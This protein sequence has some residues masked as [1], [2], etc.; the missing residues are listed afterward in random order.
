MID[1]SERINTTSTQ[2]SW[3]STSVFKYCDTAWTVCYGLFI[4]D[5]TIDGSSLSL[6]L[7][8]YSNYIKFIEEVKGELC[9][10]IKE[11]LYNCYDNTTVNYDEK[12]QIHKTKTLKTAK[13]ISV[14]SKTP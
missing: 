6:R 3:Y 7:Y 8:F 11:F 4:H 5:Q 2:H 13:F 14:E 10:R 1:I 9:K 12:Q